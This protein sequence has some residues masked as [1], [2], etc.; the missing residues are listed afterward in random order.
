MVSVITVLEPDDKRAFLVS[1]H[2]CAQLTDVYI[3]HAPKPNEVP[4]IVNAAA[5]SNVH[6][7][8]EAAII[9]ELA[10]IVMLC[11]LAPETAEALVTK[12]E[13]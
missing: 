9:I 11:T 8:V 10:L 13:S 7:L 12:S 2:S 6:L 5:P 3:S 4:S 1:T